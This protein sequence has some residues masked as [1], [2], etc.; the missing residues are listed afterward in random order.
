MSVRTYFQRIELENRNLGQI[1]IRF[2]TMFIY[3]YFV[4]IVNV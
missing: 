3:I 1:T 4:I 2:L